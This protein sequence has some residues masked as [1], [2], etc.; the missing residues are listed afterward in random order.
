MHSW[1]ALDALAQPAIDAYHQLCHDLGIDPETELI[2]ARLQH[3]IHPN[4]WAATRLAAHHHEPSAGTHSVAVSQEQWAVTIAE[5]PDRDP[6]VTALLLT[7]GL[8]LGPAH[9]Y[10]AERH[11]HVMVAVTTTC[12]TL[13]AALADSSDLA[14]LREVAISAALPADVAERLAR[15]RHP[16]VAA[17]A[18]HHPGLAAGTVET[19]ARRSPPRVRVAVAARDDLQPD[20]VDLLASDPDRNVRAAIARRSDLPDD[21]ALRLLAD[22][23]KDVIRATGT[24]LVR[25]AALN[26]GLVDELVHSR[27]PTVRAAIATH[28][29]TTGEQLARLARDHASDVRGA[30][31]RH[32]WVPATIVAQ[33]TADSTRWVAQ[34]ARALNGQ[35]RKAGAVR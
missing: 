14:T 4:I 5:D 32:P 20:L 22:R 28:P 10:L 18:A 30:V 19:L 31:L 29:N 13:L 26:P 15:H 34:Y 6:A 8:T 17:R 16:Q 2:T 33:L 12:P 9:G 23:H 27:H 21:L 35:P 25:R 11:A 7:A 1:P 3:G 24:Q